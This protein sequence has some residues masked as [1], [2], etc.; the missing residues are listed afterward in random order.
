[1]NK[2]PFGKKKRTKYYLKL[3]KAV[4]KGPLSQP[5]LNFL[6]ARFATTAVTSVW[7]FS[8]PKDKCKKTSFVVCA[9]RLCHQQRNEGSQSVSARIALL[10]GLIDNFSYDELFLFKLWNVLFLSL[11]MWAVRVLAHVQAFVRE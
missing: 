4:R 2:R 3:V 5:P 11:L 6:K 8:G 10:S 9:E 7:C 1:M